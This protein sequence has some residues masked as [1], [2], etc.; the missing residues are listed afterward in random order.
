MGGLTVFVVGGVAFVVLSRGDSNSLVFDI[1]FMLIMVMQTLATVT[2][3]VAP[4]SIVDQFN[5]F[6]SVISAFMLG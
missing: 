1:V 3:C 4:A 2:P 5:S 6:I